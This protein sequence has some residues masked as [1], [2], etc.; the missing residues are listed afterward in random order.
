M[1][2]SPFKLERYFN[3]REFK[4][5]YL[6]C[7]SNCEPLKLKELLSMADRE[8]M[9]LWDELG[10][11][12]T[13]SAGHPLLRQEIAGL[14][15]TI[16][17]ED[18]LVAAPEECIFLALNT[19]LKRGD[20]VVV[21]Y[22]AYQSLYEI[23]VSLGCKV[24]RWEPRQ[25]DD[26]WK[27]DVGQLKKLAGKK[28]RLIVVNFPHNPTGV[29]PTKDEFGELVRIAKASG[30]IL[31]SDEMYR[32]LEHDKADRLEA[33]CDLYDNAISLCGLSK[34]FSLAG[35]RLGW[36][37]THNKEVLDSCA[38][39]KDYTTICNGAA[40]EVLGIMGL[41]AREKIIGQNLA[42][43]KTNLKILDDFMARHDA[44]FSWSRPKAGPI[45]FP[46]LKGKMKVTDFCDRLYREKGV[47][48]LPAHVYDFP[49]N[50]F[51]IA[52]GRKDMPGA[53]KVLEEFVVLSSPRK[54]GSPAFTGFP[55]EF[56]P[57]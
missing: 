39:M 14:Y 29:L 15:R 31:F 16:K 54:R 36:L 30:A 1:Q 10:L 56:T 21:T 55:L 38:V 11:G 8:A 26:G 13:E 35:L 9:K 18:V 2:L 32:Y 17:P 44:L 3:E 4:A 50:N 42:L 5:R 41:R 28:T 51:R 45:A 12:Y 57:E 27:F 46:G 34:S 25:T 53:L 22:P 40:S 43:I 47:L 52:F 6:L 20:H 49:C 23:A 37:A 7:A 24:S 19:I 33:A 48:L